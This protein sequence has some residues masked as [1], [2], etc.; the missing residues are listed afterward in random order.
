MEAIRSMITRIVLTPGETGGM[1]AV[2][3]G[4]LAQILTICEG[5]ERKQRPP[6]GRAFWCCSGESSVGGCGGTQHA[7]FAH[8]RATPTVSIRAPGGEAK[9]CFREP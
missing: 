5:A 1:G 4:D 6:S 2:L 7:S 9:P 8:L 3:E